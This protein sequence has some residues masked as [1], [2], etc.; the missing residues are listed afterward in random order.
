[1]TQDFDPA[2]ARVLE[3]LGRMWTLAPGDALDADKIMGVLVAEGDP[4]GAELARNRQRA[5]GILDQLCADGLLEIVASGAGGPAERY[6][7]T[8]LGRARLEE[9]DEEE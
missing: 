7:L 3:T 2:V 9:S 5:K 8:P 4:V 1:M 6:C